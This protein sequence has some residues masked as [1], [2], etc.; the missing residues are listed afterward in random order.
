M[1]ERLLAR[2]FG[3][4]DRLGLQTLAD[5]LGVS[6]SPVQ[7]AL[8]R[9]VSEGLVLTTR[10]GYLVRPITAELMRESHDVRAALEMFAVEQTL[11]RGTAAGPRG[12]PG[13][14][15]G[16]RRR[17][18]TTPCSSTSSHTCSPTRRSTS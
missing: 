3:P 8:T 6:R 10:R 4:N 18:S 2:H 7:H 5:E 17:R 14:L 11:R 16:G 9:L 13:R 12:A 15:R 1:R